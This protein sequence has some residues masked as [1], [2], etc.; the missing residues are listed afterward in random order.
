M[1]PGA[2]TLPFTDLHGYALLFG[3]IILLWA[4]GMK[5][6]A[7]AIAVIVIAW[8]VLCGIWTGE[9]HIAWLIAV[10]MSGLYVLDNGLDWLE[11]VL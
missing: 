8:F 11:S 1:N 5:R 6:T 2:L 3:L 4:T 10:I 9:L 7:D